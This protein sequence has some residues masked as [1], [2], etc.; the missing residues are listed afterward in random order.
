MIP[1]KTKTSALIPSLRKSKIWLNF[2]SGKIRTNQDKS[3]QIRTNQDKSGQSKIRLCFCEFRK[4]KVSHRLLTP[5]DMKPLVILSNSHWSWSYERATSPLLS[6]FANLTSFQS[7][8]DFR[9]FL[10]TNIRF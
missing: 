1:T 5:P 4:K 2:L 8:N 10:H 9:W 6:G 3:G 7:E